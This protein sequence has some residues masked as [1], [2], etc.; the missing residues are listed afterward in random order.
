VSLQK[1]SRSTKWRATV[2]PVAKNCTFIAPEKLRLALDIII[3]LHNMAKIP[4]TFTN[5]SCPVVTLE[6]YFQLP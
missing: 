6:L 2:Q 3:F 4:Y 1:K 5:Y